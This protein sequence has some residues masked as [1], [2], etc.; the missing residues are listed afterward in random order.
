MLPKKPNIEVVS[1]S[2]MSN[3][4]LLDYICDRLKEF[5]DS[6]N[7]SAYIKYAAHDKSA[8]FYKG[9]HRGLWE[10]ERIVNEIKGRLM[11]EQENNNGNS[12]N[13]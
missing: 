13:Y 5:Y 1:I 12:N 11:I 3:E 9:M 7:I 2:P 8:Q 10:C 6:V 4:E